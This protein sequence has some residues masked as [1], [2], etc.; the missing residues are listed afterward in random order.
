MERQSF[1]ERERERILKSQTVRKRMLGKKEIQ[2][3]RN[4]DRQR[5]R[6]REIDRQIEKERQ[7]SRERYSDIDRDQ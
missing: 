2:T 5:E 4:I 1:K 3:D 7:R 6:D